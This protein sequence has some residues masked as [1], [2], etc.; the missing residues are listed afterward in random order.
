VLF[1]LVGNPEYYLVCGALIVCG[2]PMATDVGAESLVKGSGMAQA[3]KLLAE[4]GYDGTPVVIMA[5]G[6]V[7][8]LK[9][10]PIVAAQLLRDAGFKVDV[11]ATDWQ[12]V[13][14]RRASQKP[15]KEGGW[16]M[17]FTNWAGA[18][19]MNPIANASIGGRG[20][21]GGWFGWAEDAKIEKMK[22]AYARSGSLEEQKKIATE[23][24]KEAYDQVI[25]IPLGQYL[26]PSA[27]RKSL[28]GVLDGPSTPI[29]WNIDKSE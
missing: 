24:Q 15:P 21:N 1:S 27:W 20:K 26:A 8:T 5:P 16:N 28:S 17:F 4:S 10:Q 2:T 23:I 18:D 12:T 29:F 19:V 25:Y 7:V 13:V 22:D 3:K 6:D 14:S 9:A 11:Q